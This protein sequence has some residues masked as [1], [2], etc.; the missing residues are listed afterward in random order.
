ML[1][2]LPLSFDYGLY[3]VLMAFQ[4]GGT[5]VL[6]RSF[7]Y[8]HAV[9]ESLVRERVTGFQIVPTL[10]ALLLQLDLSRYDFSSLRYLTST[11]AALPAAHVDE[12]AR[13]LPHVRIYSMYGLT[14]CKR[15]S[16][17]PPSEI[18]RRPTSVGRGMPNQEVY[19]VDA[20]GVRQSSGIGELV[21]RGSHVM[22]GY[23]NQ[24]DETA[25]VLRPGPIA[26]ESV[27]HSGDIFRMDD[28]G[29]LYFVS[30]T[31]D[32]IKTRGEKVSPREV[33]DVLHRL[34]GVAEAVVVAVPDPILGE[35]IKAI[36][37]PKNGASIAEQDVWRHCSAHLEDF[38][39]PQVVE[40][41]QALPKTANG[42]ADRKA[43]AA[44][45]PSAT[46]AAV[47]VN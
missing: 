32:I 40:F 1:N 3:Q 46:H 43:L 28:D 21:I 12:L 13:R 27:L 7:T 19:L 29:F 23:W 25:K 17:L 24:P 45:A 11:G 44:A 14:E 33:E 41:R 42:K 22:Q 39:V 6:E 26:G 16:Y 30:R 36:V 9:L 20:A 8:I 4:F 34:D 38:M 2:V 10:A 35:A 47:V 15:V 31:D 18:A 5:V 37:V